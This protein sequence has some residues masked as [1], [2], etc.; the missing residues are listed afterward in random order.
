MRVTK[1]KDKY[2]KMYECA[3]RGLETEV[4]ITNAGEINGAL[5]LDTRPETV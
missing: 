2:S 5:R 3:W 1:E 4:R